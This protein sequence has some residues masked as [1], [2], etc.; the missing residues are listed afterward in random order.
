M[1]DISERKIKKFAILTSMN[2]KKNIDSKKT[3]NNKTVN[4]IFIKGLH[5]LENYSKRNPLEINIEESEIW[6]FIQKYK[7]TKKYT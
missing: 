7:N 5:N 3:L 2:K 6:R 4:T 1:Q